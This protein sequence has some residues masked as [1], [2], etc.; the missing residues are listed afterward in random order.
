MQDWFL[1]SRSIA[2][3]RA[4]HELKAPHAQIQEH[5]CDHLHN[6]CLE[7]ICVTLQGLVWM[8]AHLAMGHLLP[9]VRTLG[10]PFAA[11]KRPTALSEAVST[12]EDQQLALQQCHRLLVTSLWNPQ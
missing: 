10:G 8:T 1:S 9:E 3:C 11:L 7:E 12:E 4:L 6:K 2:L 5:K